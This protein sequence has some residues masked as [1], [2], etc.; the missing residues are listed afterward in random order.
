VMTAVVAGVGLM[1]LLF[2]AFMLLVFARNRLLRTVNNWLVA[3]LV[4]SDLFYVITASTTALLSASC[5][6]TDDWQ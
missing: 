5:H 4:T 1:S 3:N 6:V 2:N